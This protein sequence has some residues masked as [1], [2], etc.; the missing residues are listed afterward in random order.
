MIK[1]LHIIWQRPLNFN[2]IPTLPQLWGR[3]KSPSPHSWGEGFRATRVGCGVM[4]GLI[5]YFLSIRCLFF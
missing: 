1:Q 5:N 4:L 2:P 3:A